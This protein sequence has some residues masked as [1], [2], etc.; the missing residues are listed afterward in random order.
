MSPNLKSYESTLDWLLEPEDP[1]ARFLAMR[2][3]LDL[4]VN[5]PDFINARRMAHENGPI[6]II[7]SSMDADGYWDL[8][9]PGYLPKYSSTVWSLIML[10][11][12][13]A[14]VADDER[15]GRAC[16]YYLDQAMTPEGLISM[17]GTP[18]GTIDC[19]QGN[20]LW[21]LTALGFEHQ[22]LAAA[23]DWMARS[24][25]G[26]GVSPAGTKD[27]ERRYY[28]GKCGPN[29]ACGANGN[30][31]CAWGAVKVMLAFSLLPSERRTS[32]IDTAIQAGV[33]FL[34]G[35]DPASAEYPHAYSARPSGNWWKFGF[36]VF[37][38]TDLLQLAEALIGL[39]YGQ[40]PRL[41][42]VIE[43]I[44]DKQDDLGRWPLEY[45]YAG[46]TPV[47]FGELKQPNKWVT[48][49]ALRVLKRVS[50]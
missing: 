43:I 33:D 36:P 47:N 16:A 32:A 34:L 7:L 13:G 14:S 41:A 31:S 39:G 4:D 48:I 49:R 42:S 28:A 23:F 25:T 19:L 20:M 44:K 50:A 11:Q 40:D 30:Q 29:F 26:D 45:G 27:V 2:D 15:V 18:G 38:N 46:K 1:G 8:P 9:G 24:Q 35:I 5:Q 10:A 12:L 21:A 37:Y 17:S 3:L 22:R 6:S